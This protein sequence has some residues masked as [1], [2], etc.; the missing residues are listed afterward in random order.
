MN[1]VSNYG[2][3]AYTWNNSVNTKTMNSSFQVSA[4]R[5]MTKGVELEL[6]KDAL[7]L[8]RSNTTSQ[9]AEGTDLI[10]ATNMEKEAIQT[11]EVKASAINQFYKNPSLSNQPDPNSAI[12]LGQNFDMRL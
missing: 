1:T 5:N 11:K 3:N 12:G 9:K 7:K 8:N 6:S 2:V 10:K 4:D